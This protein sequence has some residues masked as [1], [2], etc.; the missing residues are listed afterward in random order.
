MSA[1]KT[2]FLLFM[3]ICSAIFACLGMWQVKRLQWKNGL[4]ASIEEQYKKPVGSSNVL[5]K[6]IHSLEKD[7]VI[8]GRFIGTPDF[9]KSFRLQGQIDDGKQTSHYMLP[10]TLVDK[11]IVLIDMGPTFVPPEV[12]LRSMS[13]VTGLLRLAPQPNQFTPKNDPA[14]K[15]WYSID[16]AQLQLP[17]LLPFVL[18]PERTPWHIFPAKKPELRNNHMQYATFW[19]SLSLITFVLTFYFLKRNKDI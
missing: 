1:K 8:R 2:S 13:P 3:L 18:Y 7:R 4:V 11:S 9:K 17:K 19:F 12:P 6:D 16:G 5:V 10:L 15:T 14:K